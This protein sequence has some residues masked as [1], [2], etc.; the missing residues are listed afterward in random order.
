MMFTMPAATPYTS[1]RGHA[2]TLRAAF[3]YAHY[4]G[5]LIAR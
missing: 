2:A 1:L 3:A 4:A 5:R